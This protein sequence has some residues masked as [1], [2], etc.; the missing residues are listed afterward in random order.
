M[1]LEVERNE[2]EERISYIKEFYTYF[3]FDLKEIISEKFFKLV[4]AASC[5]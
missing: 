5:P 2:L 1:Y 4:P 3:G